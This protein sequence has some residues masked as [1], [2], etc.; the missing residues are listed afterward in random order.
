MVYPLY[1]PVQTKNSTSQCPGR[2]QAF[3]MWTCRHGL[4]HFLCFSTKTQ[5]PDHPAGQ[6]FVMRNTREI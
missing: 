4:Y 5:P 6:I 1:G 3:A 2:L